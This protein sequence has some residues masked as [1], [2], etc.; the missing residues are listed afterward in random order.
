MRYKSIEL[1]NYAGI[2][3]GM[4]LTQIKIDFTQCISNKIIIRG[5]NGSGKSTLMSA[6]NLILT[7]M[8]NS[9]QMLKLERTI[10][11]SDNG[12]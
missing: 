2:Y 7:A 5:S 1:I 10:V 11:I 8:I 9:Y 6:I 3:N 4:G 12:I